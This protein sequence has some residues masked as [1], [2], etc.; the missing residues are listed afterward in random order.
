VVC[1]FLIKVLMRTHSPEMLRAVT[2]SKN[3]QV[4]VRS[5]KYPG[6]PAFQCKRDVCYPPHSGPGKPGQPGAAGRMYQAIP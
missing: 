4:R 3:K 5:R 6:F 2:K 1:T